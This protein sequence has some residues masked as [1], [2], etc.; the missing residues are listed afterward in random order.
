MRSAPPDA[1]TLITGSRVGWGVRVESW[2]LGFGAQEPQPEILAESVPIES[3]SLEWDADDVVS[4][5]LTF[6]VPADTEWIPR[7]TTDPLAAYGQ[8]LRVMALLERPGLSSVPLEVPL[9]WF[10]IKSTTPDGDLLTVKARDPRMIIEDARFLAPWSSRPGET[11]MGVTRRLLDYMIPVW[12]APSLSDRACP[13]RTWDRERIDALKDLMDA[14]PATGYMDESGVLVLT[15][16]F[17]GVPLPKFT[18]R[19]GDVGTVISAVPERDDAQGFNAMVASGTGADGQPVWGAAFVEAPHP[20]FYGNAITGYGPY[21]R[22]PGFYTSDLLTTTL[23]CEAAARSLLT[24]AMQRQAITWRV[25]CAPDPRVEIGD[26]AQLIWGE[27]DDLTVVTG[28][29][30][31]VRLPATAADGAMVLYIGEA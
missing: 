12:F 18:F 7:R 14:W 1:N 31:K 26:P 17:Q 28:L 9:G 21:G 10:K 30:S 24:K 19:D 27:G 15:A 22:K 8:Q 13:V 29:V 23:Q 25:E 4:G 20:M 16:P 5:Q 6:Q 2:Q 3:G 11:F